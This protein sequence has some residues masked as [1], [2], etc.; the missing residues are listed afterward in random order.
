M[1]EHGIECVIA[2]V[3]DNGTILNGI[4]VGGEERTREGRTNSLISSHMFCSW[5]NCTAWVP[6]HK[7][8]GDHIITVVIPH[9]NPGRPRLTLTP[10][11]TLNIETTYTYEARNELE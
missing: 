5:K 7:L 3:R 9:P 2:G 8:A 6:L 1:R 11:R 10:S 4:G